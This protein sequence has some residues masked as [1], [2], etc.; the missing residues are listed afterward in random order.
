MGYDNTVTVQ[1]GTVC[2]VERVTNNVS[3]TGSTRCLDE[4]NLG[5]CRF[6]SLGRRFQSKP[7]Q[8]S[9]MIDSLEVWKALLL[10]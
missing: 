7:L 10:A 5:V 8:I 6:V 1:Y 3:V 4:T 2:Y 9:A